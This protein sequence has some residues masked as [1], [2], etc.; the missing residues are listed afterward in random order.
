MS[1]TNTEIAW[2]YHNETKHSHWSV[3][4]NAH[5]LDWSNQPLPFKIYP[6]LEQVLLPR[7]W[8][9]SE[10][11]ALSALSSVRIDGEES[12][13]DL[14][15]LARLLYFSAGITKKKSYP[16]GT[17]LFRAASCTGALYEVELYVICCDLVGLSAGV[18][19]FNPGDFCLRRLRQG[20]YRGAL[21]RAGGEDAA[22]VS[23]PVTIVSTGT[24]WRN[25]WKYQART[26]RHFGWDNG[27]ITANLLAM[28][29]ALR[30]PSRLILRFV[31]ED[32]N[33]LLSLDTEREVALSLVSVGQV[34]DKATKPYPPIEPLCL[35]TVPLSKKEVD[36]PEMRVMHAATCLASKQDARAW[37]GQIPKVTV[38]AAKDQLF[39]LEPSPGEG[40]A[41][42]SLEEVI[43]RR[44]SSRQFERKPISFQELSTLLHNSTQGIPADFL[45]PPGASLNDWYLIVNSVEGLPAGAY[46]LHRGAVQS[47]AQLELLREGSFRE[48]AGYLGLEQALPADASVDIF[49]LADLNSVF[50]R[51]GN[52]G[53]RAVQLEAGIL[54]GKLY[55]SAY[56]QGL[57]AT[58]LTFYDDDVIEF[59]SPHAKGKSAIFLMAVGH[60]KKRKSIGS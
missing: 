56:A 6:D 18:Y 25:A 53:Y 50:E 21:V 31:D 11:A 5:Y 17:I 34:E 33:R 10:I 28:S 38:S 46:V 48:E 30:L 36:Y 27:T 37:G 29:V 47:F 4:Q 24:Y 55:L 22:L 44:G 41:R 42:R 60:G 15:C 14:D 49:F 39:R 40:V 51:L 23:A 35:E 1:N 32:V 52:R 45:D 8:E 19:H 54:G 43:L 16:G 2:T 26:Y 12:C 7:N 57:G 9:Q 59:F 3:R 13:L 20:D 58:G